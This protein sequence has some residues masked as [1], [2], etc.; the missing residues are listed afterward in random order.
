MT[1]VQGFSVIAR[2]S[3]PPFLLLTPAIVFF[4]WAIVIAEGGVVS[5]ERLVLI[6]ISALSAA[7]ASNLL[8]E[9]FDFKNGL[10]QQ[11]TPT[12][13]SG[14]SQA[15]VQTPRMLEVVKWAGLLFVSISVWSGLALVAEVGWQ[16]LLLGFLGVILLIAYTPIINKMPWLCL[17]AP[18][19]GYG[20]VMFVGAY[21]A[22]RGDVGGAGVWLFPIPLL[23]VS[24]LLLLNQFPDVD[25][26]TKVG[27][28]HSV[29]AWGRERSQ[30]V[31]ALLHA[32]SFMW[33]TLVVVLS[34]V[35]IAVAWGM[36]LLPLSLWGVWHSRAM[37]KGQV[38]LP[39][40][41]GNVA[42]VLLMPVVMG[43][44]LLLF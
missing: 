21:W 33:L 3:R 25:A 38:V 30:W 7:I 8:N 20:V 42:V 41:A 43:L 36:L 27:R 6:V 39:A 2:A 16:L 23:L 29:I 10:D 11:T 12:P 35:P 22:L 19:L 37:A 1:F 13:F 44:G 5:V 40:M 4:A 17:F 32:G 15:L 28:Y 34:I 26:D 9:F 14:G 18:G 24:A 31:F